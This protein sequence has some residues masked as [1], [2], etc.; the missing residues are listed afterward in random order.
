MPAGK[1]EIGP[2][3]WWQWPTVLS[4]DAP[5][6]ALLWQ[7]ELSRAAG[8]TL[9]GT[10]VI[11]LGSSVWLAYVADRWI[12]G[13][14]L[15]PDSVRTQRHRF[16]RRWRWP[17][18][19]LWVAVLSADLVAAL[20]GLSRPGLAAGLALL[21]AVATYLLSHQLVHRNRSW[22][23]P[24]E[25][26]VAGLLCAGVA[27]FP[28]VRPEADL[29]GLTVPA[30]LF[31]LLCFANCALISTWEHAVDRSHGQTSFSLQFRHGARISRT[32]PWMAA[33]VAMAVAAAAG[34]PVRIAALC[35]CS[36]GGL[37]GIVDL[38][39][40]RLGWRL[41]RIL[42]DVA[43]MTPAVPLAAV[44]FGGLRA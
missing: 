29:P 27:L 6:V 23:V 12:E 44:L 20:T 14:R 15:A 13:W 39:Q 36:G 30:A 22:R 35:A 17:T 2:I 7:A 19:A 31:A 10:P 1:I 40:E 21:V 8:V 38:F 32:L 25:I 37:L 9:P 11:V 16:Y 3:Q 34:G 28:A 41:A 26:C 43:L 24:K 5:A 18:A 33:G 42:G 4:L